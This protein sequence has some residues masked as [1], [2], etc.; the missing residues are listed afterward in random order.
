MYI[1]AARI[2]I[3]IFCLQICIFGRKISLFVINRCI[4]CLQIRIFGRKIS[5]FVL[6]VHIFRT[7]IRICRQNIHIFEDKICFSPVCRR[8]FQYLPLDW[9]SLLLEQVFILSVLA[10]GL[11]NSSAGLLESSVR[12]S[13]KA[14]YMPN[15]VLLC[16]VTLTSKLT[17]SYF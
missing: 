6:N 7:N 15:E 3:C 4:F 5:I 14:K 11:T 10:G 8:L 13:A 2:N 16:W 12:Y 9:Q 17:L 1:L